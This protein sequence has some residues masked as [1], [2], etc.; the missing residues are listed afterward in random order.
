MNNLAI[1]ESKD[2]EIVE[3]I[4]SIFKNSDRDFN[5]EFWN[6]EKIANGNA[7]E[8][9][10]Q[11]LNKA[12]LSDVILHPNIIGFAEGFINKNF[13][14]K[15]DIFKSLELKDDISK[16]ELK[17]KEKFNILFKAAGASDINIHTKQKDKEYISLHY[18]ISNKFYSMFLDKN[19]LYSC[20]YFENE[21][22]D[23][24]K[25]QENKM[26]HICKK[27]MLKKGDRFLDIGCGWGS[28]IIWASK[29]YG[30]VSKGIT[31]S[32]EQYELAK[33]KIKKEGL[34][35]ICSVQL[36]DYRDLKGEEV[37]DKIVSVGMFEHVGSKNLPLYFN[38]IK[39]IL[40][41]D[42][43]F[44]N[45]GITNRCER[46]LSSN[47]SKFIQK[48]IFP[49]GELKNISYVLN[50]AESCGFDV[51]DVESLREHYY[52]TLKMWVKNL[53]ENE[54]KAI[55]EVG[56]RIFRTWILYM[57]GCAVNFKGDFINVY[58]MLLSKQKNGFII[59]LTRN[60][61]I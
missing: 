16:L 35:D 10:I 30:A 22:D 33:E 41:E 50:T 61:M 38:I 23:L 52:K 25:A 20:A 60:F 57:A 9:T 37:Y 6:G 18:D 42:G 32:R 54:K 46:Q 21:N 11:F 53:Q 51:L 56:E 5:I 47:E 17:R 27:L 39:K 48:Y 44:L 24:N 40:K 29:K 28:M 49:G 36:M 2:K 55:E 58:Q 43:L 3:M 1:K 14:I 15:G 7:P 8:F 12:F 19:M 45:H 34:E 31:I 59:P 13:D 26:D 4:K